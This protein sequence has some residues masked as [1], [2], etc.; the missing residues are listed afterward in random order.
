MNGSPTLALDLYQL[1][2]AAGYFHAGRSKDIA[3]C[4]M[5]IRRLPKTRRYL[6][7]MGIERVLDYLLELRFSSEQIAALSKLPALRSAMTPDFCEA[8]GAAAAAPTP[9]GA[10]ISRPPARR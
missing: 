7:A 1:T 8:E 6:L 2:M 3:T 4:E 9:S 5:F 10:S